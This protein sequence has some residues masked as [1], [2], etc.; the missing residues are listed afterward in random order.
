VETEGEGTGLD[1]DD[2]DQFIVFGHL[3]VESVNEE[4]V[5]HSGVIAQ[6]VDEDLDFDVG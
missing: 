4:R 5:V 3:G 6:V 2:V 1:R